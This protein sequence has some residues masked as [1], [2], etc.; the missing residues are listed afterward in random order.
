MPLRLGA[1]IALSPSRKMRIDLMGQFAVGTF[2]E[3]TGGR[4][5]ASGCAI[6]DAN[7]GSHY[8][9]GVTA[10]ARWDL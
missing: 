2:T 5:C 7:Q 10:G 1:G 4:S 3:Q 9:G 6:E 8:F